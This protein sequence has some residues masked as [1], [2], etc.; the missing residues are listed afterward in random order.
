MIEDRIRD[1]LCAAGRQTGAGVF[2]VGAGHD[3]LCPLMVY[4]MVRD[5]EVRVLDGGT[6]V[7]EFTAAVYLVAESYE[8]LGAMQAAVQAA[9]AAA[10]AASGSA[11]AALAVSLAREET[12]EP[13]A[14]A[15]RRMLSLEGYYA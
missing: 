4:R 8:Q 13:E 7:F 3:E 11:F 15:I 5:E 14:Y 12:P 10:L 2:A 9:A 6:G 1:L